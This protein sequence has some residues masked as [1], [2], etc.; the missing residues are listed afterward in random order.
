MVVEIE[1]GRR[2]FIDL[3]ILSYTLQGSPSPVVDQ[4]RLY[5]IIQ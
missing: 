5:L 1:S 3:I 4:N 2:I